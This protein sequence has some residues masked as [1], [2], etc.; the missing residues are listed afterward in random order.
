[1]PGTQER[2]RRRLSP[3]ARCQQIVEC[4]SRFIAEFGYRALTFKAIADRCGMTAPGVM[5]YFPST[6]SL[7][8]AVLDHYTQVLRRR[9]SLL[10]NNG[11]GTRLCL[12]QV[13]RD[14]WSSPVCIQLYVHLSAESTDHGHVARGYLL[15]RHDTAINAVAKLIGDDHPD[16]VWAAEAF[17]TVL[18]GLRMRWIR[19]PELD[20][21]A[22]WQ[23]LADIMYAGTP[24]SQGVRAPGTPALSHWALR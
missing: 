21:V 2:A 5:H 1:M 6:T 23:R 17:Y 10:A 15:K 14:V 13:V 24:L 12:D 16:P 9:V 7:L 20:A 18:D 11:L 22:E 4:A 8:E 3:E 19:D